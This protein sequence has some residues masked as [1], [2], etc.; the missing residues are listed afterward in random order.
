MQF[1]ELFF[2]K[3]MIK[4]QNRIHKYLGVF[5]KMS[6]FKK[7]ISHSFIL[8][9]SQM[10]KHV[11]SNRC[12]T[13]DATDQKLFVSQ[14]DQSKMSQKW[15]LES[16]NEGALAK[17]ES[18]WIDF[19]FWFEMTVINHSKHFLCIAFIWIHWKNISWDQ[20]KMNWLYHWNEDNWSNG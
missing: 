10:L 18:I 19:P 5:H 20:S 1:H 3:L 6:L 2:K 12:L 17:W 14:C 9:N 11:N 13:Y 15:H 8:Q 4:W 7:L 16:L